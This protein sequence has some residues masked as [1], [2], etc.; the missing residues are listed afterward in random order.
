MKGDSEMSRFFIINYWKLKFNNYI[1]K[2]QTKQKHIMETLRIISFIAMVIIE[3]IMIVVITLNN[4]NLKG[5]NAFKLALSLLGM[6]IMAFFFAYKYFI[7]DA[8]WNGLI[9]FMFMITMLLTYFINEYEVSKYNTMAYTESKLAF[10]ILTWI[11]VVSIIIN[12]I[13]TA[14][15]NPYWVSVGIFFIEKGIIIYKIKHYL[16]FL[17]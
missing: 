8:S 4:R 7:L 17:I 15:R 16:I 13:A 2:C 9:A 12:I 6:S 11:G 14:P 10:K 1:K 3:M 5:Q